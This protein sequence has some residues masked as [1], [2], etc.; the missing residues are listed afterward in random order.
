MKKVQDFINTHF[1]FGMISNVEKLAEL[2]AI[3]FGQWICENEF[4]SLGVG[5]WAD[6]GKITGKKYPT[7]KELYFAYQNR[8]Q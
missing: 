2:A 1:W 7:T 3:D 4:E 5:N 8:K 6:T